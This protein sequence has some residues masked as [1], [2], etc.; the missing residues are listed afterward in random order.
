MQ[1]RPGIGSGSN[2]NIV[3]GIITI[4]TSIVFIVIDSIRIITMLLLY[5]LCYGYC[6]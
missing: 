3:I 6:F 5:L 2:M 4:T 1:K